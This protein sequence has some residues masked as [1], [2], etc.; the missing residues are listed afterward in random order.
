MRGCY[1]GELDK[2]EKRVKGGSEVSEEVKGE[3][4]EQE[5]K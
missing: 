4:G 1:G 3:E 2:E 5:E